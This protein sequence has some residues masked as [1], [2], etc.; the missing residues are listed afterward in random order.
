VGIVA[1]TSK[2]DISALE[3]KGS[4]LFQAVR[5][6]YGGASPFVT[7]DNHPHAQVSTLHAD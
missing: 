1:I 5:D 6:E 2:D 7:R 3:A 4:A